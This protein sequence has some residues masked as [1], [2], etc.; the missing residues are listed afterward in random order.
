[1]LKNRTS[2][3]DPPFKQVM[4][5]L[6]LKSLTLRSKSTILDAIAVLN[7]HSRWIAT[8]KANRM[9]NILTTAQFVNRS[10]VL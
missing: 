10:I 5:M 7:V 6:R 1:M 2:T 8:N 9:P 4:F 3:I